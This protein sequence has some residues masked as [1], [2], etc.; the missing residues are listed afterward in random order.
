M[1][2]ICELSR[3]ACA[4]IAASTDSFARRTFGFP[5]N[6]DFTVNRLRPATYRDNA[7]FS[8]SG[9]G[10]VVNDTLPRWQLP[11]VQRIVTRASQ[12][13]AVRQ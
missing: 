11:T 3:S 10:V 12:A 13:P 7:G 8:D 5:L 6:S 9:K 4:P 2:C 1:A